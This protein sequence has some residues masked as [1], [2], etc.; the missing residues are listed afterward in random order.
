MAPPSSHQ[1]PPGEPSPGRCCRVGLALRGCSAA[2]SVWELH[3]I[4]P[5]STSG[6]LGPHLQEGLPVL[7]LSH[8]AP[9]WYLFSQKTLLLH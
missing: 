6:E 7:P 5:A 4:R 1:A 3:G 8:L 2:S 9:L